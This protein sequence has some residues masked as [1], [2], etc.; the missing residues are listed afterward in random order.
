M[1]SNFKSPY[2]TSFKNACKRGTSYTV[3]VHNIAKRCNKNPNVVWN[4]LWKAGLCHRQKFNGTWIYF[5]C[6]WNKKSTVTN[7]KNTQTVMWQWFCEWCIMNGCCTPMKMHDNCG[8]QKDFMTFC[9]KHFGKQYN[10]NTVK[11]TKRRTTGRT[12]SYKFPTRTRTRARRA[13]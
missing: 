1:P 4:S 10:V 3:A 9:R 13:A 2:A 5:P 12:T 6:D 11:T 7:C 8:S